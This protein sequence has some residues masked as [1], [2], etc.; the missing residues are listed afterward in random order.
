LNSNPIIPRED[1][2]RIQSDSFVRLMDTG[3]V[4]VLG[5]RP[6][7]C[8]DGFITNGVITYTDPHICLYCAHRVLCHISRGKERKDFLWDEDNPEL[9]D[10]RPQ[11][12]RQ[13][14]V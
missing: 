13:D 9:V 4:E 2:G 1:V 6:T 12:G 7:R 14:I 5:P 11:L 3:E 10:V 8:T